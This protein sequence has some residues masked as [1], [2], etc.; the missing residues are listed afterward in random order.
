MGKEA[1]PQRGEMYE[2]NDDYSEIDLVD[3]LSSLWT[4]KFMIAAVTCVCL[5][6]A[7]GYLMMTPR[8]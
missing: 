6:A 1:L 5:A 7:L 3:I 4:R 8:A 2:W